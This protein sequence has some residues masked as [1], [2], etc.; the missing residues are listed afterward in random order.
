MSYG[1]LNI[2]MLNDF[3][4]EK[5]ALYVP[6]A[7][8]TVSNIIELQNRVANLENVFSYFCQDWHSENDPEFSI[9]GKHAVKNTWGSEFIPE[10][11]PFVDKKRVVKKLRYD[12]FYE[13][14]LQAKLWNDKISKIIVVGTVSNICVLAAVHSAALRWYD[15]I[16]PLDC[17][18]SLDTT[19]MEIAKH[20]ITNVYGAKVVDFQKEINF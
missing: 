17:I 7:Q 16:V 9:W 3:V 6:E 14:D 12:P 10:L 1:I 8:G 4:N 20:Q 2:D 19:G 5:G 13:T 15:V 11:V 18:S